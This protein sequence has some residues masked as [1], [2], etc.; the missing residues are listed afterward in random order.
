MTPTEQS[1]VDRLERELEEARE[2]IDTLRVSL[3]DARQTIQD[4]HHRWRTCVGE[5]GNLKAERDRYRAALEEIREQ[6]APCWQRD[7]AVRALDRGEG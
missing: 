2:E 4:K 5:R 1:T 3:D 7:V 6:S